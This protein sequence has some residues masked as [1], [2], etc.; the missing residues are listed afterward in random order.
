MKQV[1]KIL[2]HLTKDLRASQTPL[3]SQNIANG[4][5]GLQN[6]TSKHRPVR[7]LL[8]CFSKVIEDSIESSNVAFWNNSRVFTAQ[9]VGNSFYGLQGMSSSLR[10][11]RLVLHALTKKVIEMPTREQLQLLQN[12]LRNRSLEGQVNISAY[13]LSGQNIGN[14]IWGFKNMAIS[15]DGCSQEQEAVGDALAALS[16]K[17]KESTAMMDGQNFGNSFYALHAMDGNHP[18][19]RGLLASLAHKLVTSNRA[20]SGLDIGKRRRNTAFLQTLIYFFL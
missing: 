14:A 20:F 8:Y 15:V 3:D 2:E 10:E 1:R 11:T 16:G 6:M 4:L 19:I 13:V 18:A 7:K 17:I 5:F 12:E 9:A